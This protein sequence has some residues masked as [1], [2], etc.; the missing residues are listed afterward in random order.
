LIKALLRS[1]AA[2][3]VARRWRRGAQS[4]GGP[5]A[6]LTTGPQGE[7]AHSGVEVAAAPVVDLDAHHGSSVFASTAPTGHCQGS[8]T[9]S[10]GVAGRGQSGVQVSP[11][12]QQ[13]PVRGA[14]VEH[15]CC[16][17]ASRAFQ[18]RCPPAGFACEGVG[19]QPAQAGPGR[20]RDAT[21]AAGRSAALC[22]AHRLPRR[23]A[24][25]RARHRPGTR[26]LGPQPRRPLQR[27][28]TVPNRRRSASMTGAFSA[29]A[30]TS[31]SR[32]TP[33]PATTS[34]TRSTASGCQSASSG[35]APPPPPS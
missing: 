34:W 22:N 23:A 21:A 27:Q 8:V 5:H 35:A 33:V 14:P 16:H 6:C 26:H 1:R 19:S 30:C 3:V 12:V 15:R 32:T 17:R 10:A 13:R 24:P 20:R 4:T 7:L 31:P 29:T 2:R 9:P 18:S 11:A 25:G 28:L